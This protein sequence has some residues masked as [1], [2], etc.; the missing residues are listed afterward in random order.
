MP[1]DA[2]P[3][4]VLL[5]GMLGAPSMFE[6][7][8]ASLERRGRAPRRVI[9]PVLPGHGHQP[10]GLEARSFDQAVGDLAARLPAGPLLACGYSLG[11]RLS[12]AL[13]AR[14]PRRFLSVIAVG[15]HPGIDA[16]PE[17]DARRQWELGMASLVRERGMAALVDAWEKLDLFA[18]QA[19]LPAELSERQRAA[20]LAHDPA[21]IAW[22]F[23][24]LGTGS[25]PLLS[26]RLPAAGARI[27]WV[28]GVRDEKFSAIA[29]DAA[30]RGLG[31][32]VIVADAGHNV[33]LEAPDALATVLLESNQPQGVS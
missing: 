27:T 13:A 5:H 16:A 3:T 24:V 21:G 20:R 4:C 33:A 11:A 30:A 17:I 8:L 15:G 12:I 1:G 25:M 9:A 18:T 31:R 28:A 23:E 7:L 19:R 29:R 6:P 32:A 10:W 26:S 14:E 2:E 22:A